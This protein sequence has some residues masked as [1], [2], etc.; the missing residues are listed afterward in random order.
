MEDTT[1]KGGIMVVGSMTAIEDAVLVH[2]TRDG[3]TD[4]SVAGGGEGVKR[5]RRQKTNV[6]CH[7][8]A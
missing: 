3:E 7:Q 1:S 5:E 2:T 4:H 8:L 6:T